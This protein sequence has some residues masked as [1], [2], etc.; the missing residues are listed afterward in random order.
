MHSAQKLSYAERNDDGRVGLGLNGVFQGPFEA[1]SGFAGRLRG[2]IVNV[3]R[4]VYRIAREAGCIFLCLSKGSTE[5]C[6][7]GA[8][9][10]HG[11]SPSGF[12]R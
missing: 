11:N 4:C 12:V 2:G 3:L 1:S 10:R 7:G 8:R 6:I 9:F 5:I